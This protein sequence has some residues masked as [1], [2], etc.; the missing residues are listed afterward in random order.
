MTKYVFTVDD[1]KYFSQ[2]WR[3]E[4]RSEFQ[5]G[6]AFAMLGSP[7]K[8]R[9]EVSVTKKSIKNVKLY[10]ERGKEIEIPKRGYVTDICYQ[11]KQY[12]MG[13]IKT[14]MGIVS[15]EVA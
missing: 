13:K 1:F 4:N 10:N 2:K 9:V 8:G 6:K 7:V 5:I 15:V 12:V 14:P 3:K 11:C